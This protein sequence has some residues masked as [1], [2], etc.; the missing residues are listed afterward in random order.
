M[1]TYV[2]RNKDSIERIEGYLQ[3][4]NAGHETNREIRY[5]AGYQSKDCSF[6][7]LSSP[8][9]DFLV[10]V[11]IERPEKSPDEDKAY[12]SLVEG[13]IARLI[14]ILRERAEVELKENQRVA[15]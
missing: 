10:Q 14:S 11:T 1:R 6:H 8:T 15:V 7:S 5:H 9:H 3:R 13:N 4:V 2:L 12:I